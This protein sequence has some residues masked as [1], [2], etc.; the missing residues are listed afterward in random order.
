VSGRAQRAVRVLALVLLL[1]VLGGVTALVAWS[2][3]P[4]V[5]YASLRCTHDLIYGDPRPVD[6]LVVG[7]SRTK[8]GVAGPVV[9]EAMG[10]PDAVVVNLG[11][12]W[13]G[14]LQM[15][16]EV[17]DVEATR[18]IRRAIVVEYAPEGDV[19][20]T[21]RSYYDYHP[22][23]A[24]LVP[25]ATLLE[26]PAAKPREPAYARVRDVLALVAQRVDGALTHLLDD[27]TA[28]CTGRDRPVD[29]EALDA[30][31]ARVVPT[32]VEWREAPPGSWALDE[33]NADAQRHAIAE[34]VRFA[35]A[36]DLEVLLVILPRYLDPPADP[37]YLERSE[38][39]LGAPLVAPPEAVLAELY[40]GGYSD[41]NHL[42]EPGRERF[43]RWLGGEVAGR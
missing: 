20:A 24:Q 32:G 13:R 7:S 38:E 29:E 1:G 22:E 11:R 10:D 30:W 4:G 16:Q 23:H 8:Y 6:V 28:G 27:R 42:H 37:A 35:E 34:I 43:S 36:R 25:F 26:D 3:Q 33:V 5:R 19:E 18:G 41:P 40:D 14:T 12:T 9:A 39:T 21:T 31:R 15:L 17:R 2:D